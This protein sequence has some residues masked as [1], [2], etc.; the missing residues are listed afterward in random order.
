MPGQRVRMRPMFR[1]GMVLSMTFVAAVNRPASRAP[2][3]GWCVPSTDWSFRFLKR[4]AKRD[5]TSSPAAERPSMRPWPRRWCWPSPIPRRATSAAADSCSSIPATT[6]R[7]S[8]S[9]IAKRLPA[10]A[11]ADMFVGETN[12]LGHKVV[13]VPG[14][15]RG[16]ALAHARFG[17]LPWKEL[18]A[19]AVRLAG[20]GFAIDAAVAKSIESVLAEGGDFAG[21]GPRLWQARPHA[22]ASRRPVCAARTG[23]DAADPG[24][25]RARRVLSRPDRRADRGR[26]AGRRRTDHGRGPG[27]LRGQDSRRRCTARFAATTSMGRRS[28]ARA[29]SCWSKCS[30]CSKRSI[31]LGWAAGRRLPSI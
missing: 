19:P 18:V 14:T 24:R 1:V 21:T 2:K 5:A 9:I 17:K 7:S 23:S 29:E 26:D 20:E 8:A 16:L 30:T 3:S 11:T 10:R 4:P 31:W 25:R 27:R 15:V 13:G 28:P 6:G 22:L 12:R